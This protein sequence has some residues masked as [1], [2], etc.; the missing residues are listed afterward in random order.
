MGQK[1]ASVL[2]RLIAALVLVTG[3]VYSA[4]V[5]RA[6]DAGNGGSATAYADG[7]TV[8]STTVINISADGGVATANA[9]GGDDNA[10]VVAATSETDASVDGGD[11]LVGNGGTA[12]ADASGGDVTVG[13]TV[14]GGNTGNDILIGNTVGG[15]GSGGG[16]AV[17]DVFGGDASF[18]TE[19]N[20]TAD[21][22]TATADANGGSGNT[23]LV[24][25]GSV[26]GTA[27]VSGAAVEVGNG[28][29][30]SADASGGS[31]TIGDV[32]SGGNVGNIIT[33]GDTLGGDAHCDCPPV[34]P[35]VF[36]DGG[37]FTATTV[38]NISANG[39]E[40]VAN[41]NG[42]DDNFAFVY[43][44]SAYDASVSGATVLVGNGGTATAD[45]S[46]GDVTVGDVL[47][48]EN[49]GNIIT[50]G[51]TI[52]GDSCCG[53]GGEALVDIFGGN[54]TATTEL[55]ITADGGFAEAN[56]YG[57]SGNE[58]FVVAESVYGAASVSGA[59]VEVGNGGDAFADASGGSITIGDIV[60]GGN[61]G[62]DILVGDTIGGDGSECGC[63]EGGDAT[64]IIDGG[65]VTASTTLDISASG[66]EAT[67]N[68][69]GG[70]DNFVLVY[71]TSVY[72]ASV[73]G[74][75]VLVGNGG[76]ADAYAYG[77]DITVGTIYSGENLGN[78]I[79]VGN[80]I[81]GDAHGDDDGG[82]ATVE[83]FGGDVVAETTGAITAD[84]GI[85]S[86]YANGGSGNFVVVGV[87]GVYGASVSG[88]T[89][90]VGQGGTSTSD[91]SGGT[92]E[93]GDIVSGGNTGNIITIGDTCGGDADHDDGEC[94]VPPPDDDDDCKDDCPKDDHDCP[95]PKDDDK[96]DDKKADDAKGAAAV[97]ALPDTG[98][99]TVQGQTGT[100]GL[101]VLGTILALAGVAFGLRR[102]LA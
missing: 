71:A 7:G 87:Y 99:G 4:Q 84:G 33:V 8:T 49:T 28:G 25:A 83:V 56:A 51:N 86:A 19:I 38:L 85:A 67:A 58:V 92:I 70:S 22:G 35:A 10:V 53:H 11:I 96:K 3:L 90:E 64:V 46:G 16:D 40:A 15:S 23:A 50:V 66:G 89:V 79:T 12:T 37:S 59:T 9:N 72:D 24:L 2:L 34:D 17:V 48:G 98:T 101:L 61:V 36:I 43:A 39:G 41:A 30:A 75:T 69:N 65:D 100:T 26:Y 54:V 81:G 80:T 91:A 68:A 63:G 94:P 45:A 57:G 55:N 74:A 1:R 14:S 60:S 5:A 97:S 88:A 18:T 6:Q 62:N 78:V 42:G 93:L 21:G 27:S 13:D 52:G 95:C 77:G 76:T 32:L 44:G 73:S 20:V 29:T 47:S 102:R 82:D 31:V